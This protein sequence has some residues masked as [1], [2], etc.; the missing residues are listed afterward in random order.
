MTDVAAPIAAKI[1]VV[2]I[3]SVAGIPN[4]DKAVPPIAAVV[5]SVEFIF[6]RLI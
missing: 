2:N 5:V 3:F 4:N 6:L 1:I